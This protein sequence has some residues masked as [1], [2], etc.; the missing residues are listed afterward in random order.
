MATHSS[1]LTWIISWTEESGGL[2]FMDRQESDMTEGLTKTLIIRKN[3][4]LKINKK[5]SKLK[6]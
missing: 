4:W 6:Y 1:F 5:A 2:Q 3:K